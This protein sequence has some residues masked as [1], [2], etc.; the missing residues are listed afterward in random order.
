MRTKKVAGFTGKARN[1][2]DS[3]YIEF[4]LYTNWKGE[5]F[6]QIERNVKEDGTTGGK[7]LKNMLFSTSEH[8][9]LRENWRGVASLR[10]FDKEND[11]YKDTTTQDIP[12]FLAAVLQ[13]L[14]PDKDH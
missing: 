9:A 14:L 7:G 13:D 2:S 6:V 10:G 11:T 4:Y 3:G 12:Q 5:L 1:L 8:A